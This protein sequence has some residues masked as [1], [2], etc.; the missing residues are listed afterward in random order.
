MLLLGIDLETGGDFNSPVE[1][2]FITEIGMVLWDTTFNQP[3]KMH[4][5][6]ITP[7][8]AICQD[9]EVYT[10]IT[11]EMAKKWS[12][13]IAKVASLVNQMFELADYVVAHN[14]NRFDKP[15][16]EVNFNLPEKTWIDTMTDVPYPPNC[17]NRNLSYLAQFHLLLNSFPH[18]AL[19][20][21][22]TMLTILNK[23]DLE[24][25]IK[26]AQSPVLTVEAQTTFAEKEKPKAAK[27]RWNPE[28]KVW[29]KEVKELF[30]E[31]ESK[32]WNFKYTVTKE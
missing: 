28:K 3:I 24:E 26:I 15:I 2:N 5:Y 10:G 7:K 25:V 11:N 12:T 9:A 30:F 19:T 17:T 29:Y 32:N 8:Q 1:Q 27:F 22:L 6:L 18:R 16:M 14:G 13:D 20:D 31:E 23:Y 21:V 4:N